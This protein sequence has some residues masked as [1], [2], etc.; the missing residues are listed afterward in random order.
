MKTFTNKPGISKDNFN[1]VPFD[2]SNIKDYRTLQHYIQSLLR[3]YPNDIEKLITCPE[4]EDENDWIYASFRQFVQELN[5]YAYEHRD[6]S[7]AATEP[8]ME[9]F[10]NGQKISCLSA[11]YNPPKSVPAIDYI[12]QMIDLATQVILD[13]KCFPGGIMTPDGKSYI[14]TFARR[15]YR[16]FGYSYSCHIDIFEKIEKKTHICERF[17]RFSKKYSLLRPEDIL[18][19]DQYWES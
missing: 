18:I 1:K 4:G 9:F 5:Y 12:T 6:V 15:L 13:N 7:T 10:V 3:E 11:A 14:D 16:I 17:T 2:E 8:N 19:P